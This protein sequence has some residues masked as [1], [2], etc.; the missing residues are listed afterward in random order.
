[1]RAVRRAC[2]VAGVVGDGE[3]GLVITPMSNRARSVRDS[4]W[5]RSELEFSDN[6]CGAARE[7]LGAKNRGISRHMSF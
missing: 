5:R 3:I 1:M 4:G 6:A 7:L 2:R